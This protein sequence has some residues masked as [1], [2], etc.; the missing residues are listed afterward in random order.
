MYLLIYII[1]FQ[2]RD[3]VWVWRFCWVGSWILGETL[4]LHP[5][6][7]NG[8]FST[9]FFV[10]QFYFWGCQTEIV[11]H[12][13]LNWIPFPNSKSCVL[14]I[15]SRIPNAWYL[16]IKVQAVF[17]N[18]WSLHLFIFFSK[19]HCIYWLLYSFDFY[20]C[21]DLKPNPW[22]TEFLHIGISFLLDIAGSFTNMHKR[23][24][25]PKG[26]LELV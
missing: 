19:H 22:A 5:L 1:T 15:A 11:I 21:Q 10:F 7:L 6:A 24:K 25:K 23:F 4:D 13:V 20:S 8:T 17:L 26:I 18:F 16:T 14:K 12:K 9:F 2:T 3:V